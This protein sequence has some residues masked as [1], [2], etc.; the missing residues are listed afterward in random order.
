MPEMFG[1]H[2]SKLMVLFRTDNTVQVIIHTANMIEKDWT[3]MTNAIWSSP[4][5]PRLQQ[6]DTILQPGRV[7]PIGSGA[8]FKLDLLTYLTNYDTHSVICRPLLERLMAFDF[9]GVRAALI[10]SVPGKHYFVEEHKPAWGW[11]G[12]QKCLQAVPVEHGQSEIVVQVSSIATLGAK[13]DW[14]Q[15]TLFDSL[16]MSR[17][18]NPHKPNFKVIFPT[19]DEVR[20]SLDGYAAGHSIHIKIKSAQHI[21]QLH[22]LQPML[23]HWGN[24]C[25]NGAGE[26]FYVISPINQALCLEV[27]AYDL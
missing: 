10:A 16:A 20:N 19:A 12:L 8:R 11:A 3:N 21:R 26:F 6:P 15:K 1:T 2:H 22:Y 17:T 24:D 25:V 7:L 5:L 27:V 13:S 23:H 14:L 9:S 18:Q 4:K